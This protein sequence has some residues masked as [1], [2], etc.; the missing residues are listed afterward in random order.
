MKGEYCRNGR[1]LHK[2]S[3]FYLSLTLRLGPVLLHHVLHIEIKIQ[4]LPCHQPSQWTR[5]S[6]QEQ[7]G[8]ASVCRPLL[9]F[10]THRNPTLFRVPPALAGPPELPLTLGV[11]FG[12]SSAGSQAQTM[13][14]AKAACLTCNHL[15]EKREKKSSLVTVGSK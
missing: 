7:G 8:G 10:P 9:L 12:L 1:G 5:G 6:E 3:T 13:L 4:S 14:Q 15:P 2:S 11:T